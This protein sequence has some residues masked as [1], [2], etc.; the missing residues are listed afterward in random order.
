MQTPPPWLL[1]TSLGA[2]T[3]GVISHFSRK[4]PSLVHLTDAKT[5][6]PMLVDPK[7]VLLVRISPVL[8]NNGDF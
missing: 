2:I 5:E 4:G 3:Y 7:S 8:Q 1:W 6:Q